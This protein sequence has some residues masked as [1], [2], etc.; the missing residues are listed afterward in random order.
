M[1]MFSFSRFTCVL[2]TA[3]CLGL[4]AGCASETPDQTAVRQPAQ[5]AD[6]PAGH[7]HEGHHKQGPHQSQI[8]DLG[9][10]DYHAELIHD[11]KSHTITVYILDDSGEKTTAIEAEELTVNLVHDGK[12]QQFKLAASPDDGDPQGKSSRFVSDDEELGEHIDAEDADARIVVKVAGRSYTGSLDHDHNGHE[13]GGHAHDPDDV[14]ITEKD[15][16]KPADYADA[17]ARIKTYRDQIR[18]EID[19]GRPTK[20][21]RPLDELDIVLGWLEGIAREGNV[22]QQKCKEVHSAAQKMRKLF[23]KVHANIDAK[24]DPDFASI[25][26]EVAAAIKKLE[27]AIPE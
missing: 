27:A 7:G 2:G 3:V 16:R 1:R 23:D 5:Q 9:E 20:A 6:D 24:R 22:S 26:N 8:V 17:I 10:G 25:A 15:V 18:D 4:L 19:A 13:P 11:E 14:P 21:H 12:P